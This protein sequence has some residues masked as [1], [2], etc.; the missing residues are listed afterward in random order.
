LAATSSL[1][2]AVFEPLAPLECEPVAVSALAAALGEVFADE[3]LGAAAVG[4]TGLALVAFGVDLALSGAVFVE[5][6]FDLVA[7]SDL[8][9][10]TGFLSLVESMT[11]RPE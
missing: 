3:A 2:L 6:E 10:P 1:A 8:L 9:V 11:L 4:L 7:R 5:E